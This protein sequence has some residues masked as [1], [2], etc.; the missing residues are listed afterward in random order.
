MTT[1]PSIWKERFEKAENEQQQLFARVSK[2]YDIMYAVQNSSN[3]APWRSKLYIPVLASKAWDLISRLSNVTPYFRTKIEEYELEENGFVVPEDVRE[4]QNRIDAKLHKDYVDNPDEPIKFKVADTLL[5]A[6]VAGTGW[7]KVSWEVKSEKIYNKQTDD[8]GM[9]K[10]PD[11]DEVTDYEYG[12][13]VFEPLNFFNV[14]VAPNSPSW[15]K[16]PYI[17]VRY[18]KTFEELKKKDYD[19][20]GLDDSPKYS[21]SESYNLS[22]DRLVNQKSTA[23]DDT[24]QT[25]T[26]YEC[27]ENTSNGIEVTVFAEG[28]GKDGWVRLSKPK[29]KYWHKYYPVIPFYIRKKSFSPWGES[30]F[31]NNA[32]LQ[33]GVND[34]MNHYMDNLNVA[35]DSMIMYED[36]TLT[37]DFVVEPGGEITYTG[38]VPKQFKFPEPNPGQISTV[39]NELNQAIEIATVPQ[40]ISGVPDSS[41]DKTAGTAKGISLITEAA[42]EKIGYMRDNFKQSM[43]IVGRIQ[44]SNLAQFQDS[45]EFVSY[46]DKGS[47]KI[48]ALT[49]ADYQGKIDLTIDDDSLLPLTKDEKRDI[50]LQYLSQIGQIQKLALEQYQIFGD[51]TGVPYFIYPEIVEQMSYL[52]SVKD[53]SKIMKRGV[54][55]PLP[56]DGAPGSAGGGSQDP[57]TAALQGLQGGGN[58]AQS[59]SNFGA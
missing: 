54:A 8:E 20:S 50:Y 42:T 48:D 59:S 49:P 51:P 4:R 33:S 31:E 7:A 43:L 46:P 22:R 52:F 57:I 29:K 23:N 41:T 35:L 45:V 32:T 5:D 21:D 10:N 37:N 17:I 12:C 36:G 47:E 11:K 39:M 58:G 40:Y 26:V 18:F 3:M 44:L 9:I 38:E 2:Y 24:V 27:Y 19:L 30:L 13:N 28:K 55:Q 14:F 6:T 15:A 56:P 1:K 53:A 25:A 16:A 34:L